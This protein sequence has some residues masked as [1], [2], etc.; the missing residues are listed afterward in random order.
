QVLEVPAHEHRRGGAERIVTVEH[1]LARHLPHELHHAAVGAR[2]DRQR[3][4]ELW[5]LV[6]GVTESVREG[7]LAEVEELVEAATTD[8][9]L[10]HGGHASNGPSRQRESSCTPTEAESLV[11]QGI[12]HGG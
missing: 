6:G 4:S 5:T 8:P 7:L 1:P 11:W 10:I 2:P 9:A 12:G 3:I